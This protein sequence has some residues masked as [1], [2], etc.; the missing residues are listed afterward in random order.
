M[1]II[2]SRP[3]SIE[4]LLDHQLVPLTPNMLLTAKSDVILPPPPGEFKDSDLY[5][6][7]QW[8]RVQALAETFWNRW[9]KEYL[10]LL[11]QSTKWQVKQEDL[12]KDSVVLIKDESAYRGDWKLGRVAEV[13]KGKDG[14]V[15]TAKVEL[16]TVDLDNEGKRRSTKRLY[17]ERPIHKLVMIFQD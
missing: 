11:T 7:K 12:K 4:N 6:R 2:N 1:A 16:G 5:C 17:V 15:R 8:L 9:K 3:L 10:A 13:F 14:L